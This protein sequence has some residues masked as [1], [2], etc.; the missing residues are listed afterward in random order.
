MPLWLQ[1]VAAVELNAVFPGYGGL[2]R[3]QLQIDARE[4]LVGRPG[5]AIVE[6]GELR[7]EV[8]IDDFLTCLHDFADPHTDRHR[9]TVRLEIENPD[10]GLSL[11][12]LHHAERL[13]CRET[14]LAVAG[15]FG[16]VGHETAPLVR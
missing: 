1:R 13:H 9:P 6:D 4:D 10:S 3:Q 5:I 11:A 12:H 2:L 16:L 15:H 8:R 7:L 14:A